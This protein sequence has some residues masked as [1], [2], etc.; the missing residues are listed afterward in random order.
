[1]INSMYK[2]SKNIES[3]RCKMQVRPYSQGYLKIPFQGYCN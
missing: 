3:S 1:M 2:S